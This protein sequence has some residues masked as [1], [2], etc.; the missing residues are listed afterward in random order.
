MNFE[1]AKEIE[2]KIASYFG[3]RT[4]VI[5]PNISWGMFNHECDLTILSKAGYVYEVEIKVSKSDLIRDKKKMKWKIGMSYLDHNIFRALWFAIPQKLQPF[6]EHIPEHAGIFVV[7]KNG[8]VQQ[9]RQPKIDY[10]AKKLKDEE[11]FQLARLGVLRI[12]DLKRKLLHTV[13]TI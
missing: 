8:W 11:K 7:N 5:V 13:T 2:I 12:W 1:T 4:H 3:I 9:I 6:I 10:S